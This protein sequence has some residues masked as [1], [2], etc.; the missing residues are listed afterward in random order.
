[1]FFVKVILRSIKNTFN[2]FNESVIIYDEDY[3]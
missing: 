1:M 3:Q 2:T